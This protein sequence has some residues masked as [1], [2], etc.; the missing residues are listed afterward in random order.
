MATTRPPHR[1]PALYRS[2]SFTT[3]PGLRM[4]P[5]RPVR[6]VTVSVSSL[7]VKR[8]HRPTRCACPREVH[9]RATTSVGL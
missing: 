5:S 2:W 4:A 7:S 9:P 1:L 6:N 3:A 8:S